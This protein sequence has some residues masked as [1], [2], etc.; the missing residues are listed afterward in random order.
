MSVKFCYL[1][2]LKKHGRY[3]VQSDETKFITCQKMILCYGLVQL[4]ERRNRA[5]LLRKR[6]WVRRGVQKA[7]W[8]LCVFRATRLARSRES[9]TWRF[10]SAIICS[11]ALVTRPT[12]SKQLKW[13]RWADFVASLLTRFDCL[14]LSFMGIIEKRCMPWGY[15]R[16][17]WS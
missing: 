1:D 14:W 17:L 6:K 3:G 9:S 15:Q 5:L 11:F 4:T 12:V 13:K 16:Q 10:L 7:R 2:I 8:V